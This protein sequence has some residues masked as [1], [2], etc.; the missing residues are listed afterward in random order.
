MGFPW[1]RVEL[2]ETKEEALKREVF[3]ES[4]IKCKI[5][6]KIGKRTHPNSGKEITYY[7]C[8]FLEGELKI[9]DSEE[10]SDAKWIFPKDIFNYITSD[11]F[12]PV[13]KI[14]LS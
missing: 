9:N 3:E 11:L 13:E 4:N 14:L 5:I 7:L 10:I 8:E 12:E 2:N 1:G 6:R